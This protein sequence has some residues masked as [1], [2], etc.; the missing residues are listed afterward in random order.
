MPN[1]FSMNMFPVDDHSRAHDSAE[2]SAA[3]RLTGERNGI[4]VTVCF[5]AAASVRS[6][7]PCSDEKANA[8]LS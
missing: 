7:V 2:L 5:F 8:E 3:L 6:A 4:A 1:M